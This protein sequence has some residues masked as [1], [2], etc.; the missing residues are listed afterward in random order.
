M[1]TEKVLTYTAMA[2]AGLVCLIFLLDLAFKVFGRNI[3][4]DIMFILGAGFIIWQGVET[5]REFR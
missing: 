5:V 3:A 1:E 4:L 2:L